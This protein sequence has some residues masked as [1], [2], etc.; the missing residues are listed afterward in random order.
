MLAWL[1]ASYR[2]SAT[3]VSVSIACSGS[4]GV[5]KQ[6]SI[7]EDP[8]SGLQQQAPSSSWFPTGEQELGRI[9]ANLQWH[10]RWNSES[11]YLCRGMP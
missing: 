6:G 8:Y 7:G 11:N 9:K 5:A 1:S 10:S 3:Q 4:K 2:R